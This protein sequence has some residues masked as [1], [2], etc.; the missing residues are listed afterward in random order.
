VG[1][2]LPMLQL[3]RVL[4][5]GTLPDGLGSLANAATVDVSRNNF[6]GGIPASLQARPL[7]TLLLSVQT[8][9]QRIAACMCSVQLL[10]LPARFSNTCTA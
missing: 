4:A 8:A 9:A 7:D 10:E 5:Q 2:L 6:A 1:A 3:P